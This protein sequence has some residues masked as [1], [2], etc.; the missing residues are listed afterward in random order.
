LALRG[1]V[2]VS[3]DGAKR[4]GAFYLDRMVDIEFD[5]AEN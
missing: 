4:R 5:L 1:V 3:W 2:G